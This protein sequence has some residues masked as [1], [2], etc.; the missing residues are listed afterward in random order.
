MSTPEPTG[1]VSSEDAELLA[2]LGRIA[3]IID[4]VPEDL[5]TAGRS[6][7]SLR[8]PSAVLMDTMDEQEQLLAVRSDGPSRMHF[9]EYGDVAIDLQV[10]SHDGLASI[11]GFL[12]NEGQGAGGSVVLETSAASYDTSVDPD[13]R[14][15]FAGV[16]LGLIRLQV[17]V[18]GDHSHL[19]T[20][21]VETG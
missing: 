11:L 12:T 14:F 10:S 16:P 5:L 21:W 6:L 20:R 7:F 18:P 15:T 4:P 17:E 9:F 3:D 8:D 1:L 19:T 13:G 2:R